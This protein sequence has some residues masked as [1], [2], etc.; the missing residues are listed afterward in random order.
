VESE[1]LDILCHLLSAT[2]FK[3]KYWSGSNEELNRLS[4]EDV[5]YIF[6]NRF[7]KSGE[8]TDE[9]ECLLYVCV[10]PSRV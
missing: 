8:L 1:G 5:M 7:I 4:E 2:S 9:A 3:D 10:F 6:F